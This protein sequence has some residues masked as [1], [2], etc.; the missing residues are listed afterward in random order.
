[1]ATSYSCNLYILEYQSD[2]TAEAG[3]DTNTIKITGHGLSDGDFIVNTTRRATTQ[4][5]AERGSRKITRTD[6]NTLE[7][8]G[9]VIT[10]MTNGDTIKLFKFTDRTDYLKSN[11]LKIKKRAG[12]MNEA[13]FVLQET[14][15]PAGY[16]GDSYVFGDNAK[17]D[18]KATLEYSQTGD[19]WTSK[20]VLADGK[21][22]FGCSNINN[23]AYIYC[24]NTG[25]GESK[26]CSE[27]DAT[28]NGFTNKTDAPDPTRYQNCACTINLKGYVYAGNSPAMSD[29][30]EYDATG[31]SWAS[32]TS[33][34]LSRYNHT[35][36]ATETKGYCF[37]GVS[38]FSTTT[39]KTPV[40]YDPV[41]NSWSSKTA[42]DQTRTDPSCFNI[43]EKIY[44][45][46]GYSGAAL[47]D[48]DEYDPVGNSWAA[49]TDGNDPTRYNVASHGN[50]LGGTTGFVFGGTA[51][52]NTGKN[53]D[54]YD[55]VGNSWA[56]KTDVTDQRLLCGS[57]AI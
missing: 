21:A 41:G 11:S 52:T 4:L 57:V 17:T 7:V 1:M 5:S 15:T 19:S 34:S 26:T 28:T 50:T 23:K 31:N 6:A 14:Y 24:G 43:S 45:S 49:K 38:N 54:A 16:P 36:N 33:L 22:E 20:A 29:N 46:Y 3:T 53:V 32:K 13:S 2:K 47:K 35:A 56:G 37:G 30:D 44:V 39:G 12:G 27:Y 18:G 55:P 25:A 9:A 42:N 48:N 40:E 10:G 51:G 8:V